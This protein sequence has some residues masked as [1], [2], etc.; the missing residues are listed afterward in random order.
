[1]SIM[2]WMAFSG[3]KNTIRLVLTLSYMAETLYEK[4]TDTIRRKNF[5]SMIK[6]VLVVMLAL[7]MLLGATGWKAQAAAEG[8]LIYH[9]VQAKETLKSVAKSHGMTWQDLASLNGIR[10]PYTITTG[11]QLCV[12]SLDKTGR[13]PALKVKKTVRD[14]SLS[15]KASNLPANTQVDIYLATFGTGMTGGT[16]IASVNTGKTGVI[17]GYYNWPPAL[18]GVD[19]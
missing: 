8:C 10:S 19:R 16:K 14:A 11:Q 13:V 6:K 18:K 12:T 9:S 15:L 7:V 17:D 2:G 1:M 3:N 5:M 4:E